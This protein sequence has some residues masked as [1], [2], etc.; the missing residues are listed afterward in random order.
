MRNEKL[1]LGIRNCRAVTVWRPFIIESTIM[2]KISIRL[3]SD[4][5]IKKSAVFK[6]KVEN[7]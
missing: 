4:N 1:E 5:T 2:S 3:Y 7:G 6:K